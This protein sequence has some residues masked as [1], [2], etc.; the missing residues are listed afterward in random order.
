MDSN[1]KISRNAVVRIEAPRY[2]FTWEGAAGIARVDTNEAMT[3]DHQFEIASVGKTMTAVVVLQLWEEGALG[4]KGLD[5]TLEDL[6]AFPPEVLDMLQIVKGVPYGRKIT[7]RQLLN[8][9]TGLKDVLH[10][11]ETGMG[12]DFP[13]FRGNAPGSLQY[14]CFFDME[15]GFEALMR[16]IENG[17]PEGC[18]PHDYFLFYTWSPWN[19]DSWVKNPNDKMAGL[20]NFYLGGANRTAL[21]EPGRDLYYSNTNYVILGLLIE[22]ITGHSLQDELNKRIFDKLDMIHTYLS[23]STN[24]TSRPWEGRLS[25]FWGGN[26]PLISVDISRSQDWGGGG[27][28]STVN[29]LTAFIRGL[30][31][32]ELFQNAATLEEMLKLPSGL[33]KPYGAGIVVWPADGGHILH[34]NGAP[35]SWIEYNSAYD[36]S[37]VGTT[38]DLDRPDR[39][40][41]LRADIYE[42]LAKAG[43]ESSAMGMSARSTRLYAMMMNDLPVAPLAVL[44]IC[45]LVFLSAFIVW[46]IHAL[47]ERKRGERAVFLTRAS[48]WLGAGIFSLDIAFIIALVLGILGNS[49]QLMFCFLPSTRIIL[50]L[51]LMAAV[52]TVALSVCAVPVWRDKALRMTYRVHYTVAVLAALGFLWSLGTFGLVVFP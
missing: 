10:D 48:R 1:G 8:H 38:N 35:G 27:E 9:T 37:I 3:V 44:A 26:V 19:Y 52:L 50:V 40:M 14:M 45:I 42:A 39:F 5:A 22:K 43:L 18:D 25:D 4:E 46:P 47:G 41:E 31:K 7:V 51:P 49:F 32:G 20:L 12:D 23:H 21:W 34:H 11:S 30:A 17:V 15:K 2:Q 6:R 28:V 29:D 24:Q 13:E 16:C 33:D 36:L